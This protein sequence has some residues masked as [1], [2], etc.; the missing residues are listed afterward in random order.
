MEIQTQIRMLTRAQGPDPGWQTTPG[1]GA[2]RRRSTEPHAGGAAHPKLCEGEASIAAPR[3]ACFL[4]R[5]RQGE[6][7]HSSSG[8]SACGGADQITGQT[9]QV[10]HPG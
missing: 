3:R 2:Q 10:Q 4:Q 6:R 9:W 5:R 1:S 8:A 7:S